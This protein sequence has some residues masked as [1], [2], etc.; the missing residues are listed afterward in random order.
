[1]L[2]LS[3]VVAADASAAGRHGA[4]WMPVQGLTTSHASAAAAAAHSADSTRVNLAGYPDDQENGTLWVQVGQG[5]RTANCGCRSVTSHV[6]V[7]G[8]A[9]LSHSLTHTLSTF[10]IYVCVDVRVDVCV[11]LLLE[12][13]VGSPNPFLSLEMV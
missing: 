3:N 6:E 4:G 2:I 13:Q 7:G 12:V 9:S 8:G 5:R 1:M 11:F 10:C